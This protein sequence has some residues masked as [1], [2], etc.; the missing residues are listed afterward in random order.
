MRQATRVRSEPEGHSTLECARVLSLRSRLSCSPLSPTHPR[1]SFSFSRLLTGSRLLDSLSPTHT[2]LHPPPPAMKSLSLAAAAVLAS[3]AAHASSL[4]DGHRV[5][6]SLAIHRRG[7][8]KLNRRVKHSSSSTETTAIWWAEDGW[9]GACGVA[10]DNA[11]MQ[12]GLPLSVYSDPSAKSALCGTTAYATNPANGQSVTVTVVD[13]SDRTDFTTFSKAAY[14][15][16][17]GNL[18]TGMLPIVLSLSKD[19]AAAA[20]KVAVVNVASSATSVVAAASAQPEKTSA[21]AVPASTV[22]AQQQK[23]SDKVTQAPTSTVDAVASSAA[24]KKAYESQQAQVLA[25]SQASADAAAAGSSPFLFSFARLRTDGFAWEI[26]A[27]SKAA[28][29]AAASSSA[30]AAAA[31]S[32]K[33]AA[34]AAAS[35]SA[36]AAAAASSKAAADAAASSSSAAAAA[37]AKATQDANPNKGGNGGGNG[38]KVFSGGIATFFYQNGVAGNCGAVNPDSA[39]IV[40]LPTATYANGAHCGQTVTITRVDTG[41]S[42]QA[43]VADSCPTCDNSSCL[44]LSTAAFKALGGTDAMGVFDI[45]W[46]FN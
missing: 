41:N 16:L 43:K 3:T 22:V 13:G 39:L 24:A 12:V 29:D 2:R 6:R 10:T 4:H 25:A 42:I 45:T 27:S 18:D 28:A 11:A 9:Q 36:A 33:A 5:E 44:D 31:A 30:A 26:A 40:A 17:G 7:A 32:S 35:S 15:A 19:A 1:R 37:A 21:P 8:A 20:K 14:S 23:S 38:G 46:H 34:D